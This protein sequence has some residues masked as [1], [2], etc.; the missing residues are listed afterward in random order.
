[1]FNNYENKTYT[2]H[3]QIEISD[4][5]IDKKNS[6][7]INKKENQVDSEQKNYLET[8]FQPKCIFTK[9]NNNISFYLSSSKNSFR[10]TKNKNKTIAPVNTKKSTNQSNKTFSLAQS[11]GE[12]KFSYNFNAIKR[13]ISNI[14]NQKNENSNIDRIN[15]NQLNT[16]FKKPKRTIKSYKKQ[17]NIENTTNLNMIENNKIMAYDSDINLNL[18]K[19]RSKINQMYKKQEADEICFPSKKTHSPPSSI[20]NEEIV[21]KYQTHTL[22]YQNFFGSFNGLKNYRVAKSSSKI[23]VNQLNDFNIDKLIEIGDKYVNLKKPVLPLGK[24]MNNNILYYKKNRIKHVKKKIPINSKIFNNKYSYDVQVIP[25]FFKFNK[26]DMNIDSDEKDEN[27]TE[28]K[29]DNKNVVK[30]IIY[31]NNLKNKNNE[32]NIESQPNSVIIKNLDFINKTESN[33]NLKISKISKKFSKN[34]KKEPKFEKNSDKNNYEIQNNKKIAQNEKLQKRLKNSNFEQKLNS[35]ENNNNN[36]K[37]EKSY[38]FI[39]RRN[40]KQSNKNIL[41]EPKLLTDDESNYKRKILK[42]KNIIQNKEILV[43]E[44]KKY[45]KNKKI[46]TNFYYNET[47]N[48]NYYGYDERHNLED[49]ID[50]HAY[51]ESFHSRKKPLDLSIDK[52]VKNLNKGK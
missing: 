48:K 21:N 47:K 26:K 35:V 24:I 11:L 12:E 17:K 19:T 14:N 10:S 41:S 3:I 33:E 30:K 52:V 28:I 36:N 38:I 40:E 22:K 25:N 5:E 9:E 8:T 39:N 20:T 43:T 16:K 23:K 49:T 51:Y 1:M 6:G 27:K 44:N 31:K 29:K 4:L 15:I 50:N 2:N 32:N 34:D 46:S 18:Q 37:K 7:N 13:K 45:N 42:N